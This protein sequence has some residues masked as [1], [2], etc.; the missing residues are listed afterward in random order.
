MEAR[1]LC[2]L[3]YAP[4]RKQQADSPTTK[5][6][7]LVRKSHTTHHAWLADS[8]EVWSRVIPSHSGS[9]D[10]HVTHM[11]GTAN[12]SP[13]EAFVSDSGKKWPA[14]HV[15]LLLPDKNSIFCARS[16]QHLMVMV[17]A[18]KKNRDFGFRPLV[19]FVNVAG[20]HVRLFLSDKHNIAS[21]RRLQ[22]LAVMVHTPHLCPTDSAIVDKAPYGTATPV[23][24]P[25]DCRLFGGN[26][27]LMYAH[28]WVAE[29]H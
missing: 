11:L 5:V 9:E 19:D 23:A 20:H 29:A 25:C 15:R 21:A 2:K 22:H 8:D 27:L 10:T 18:R 4:H 12:I 16:S 26:S 14:H 13:G 17:H 6:S 3:A 1:R 7:V 24:H 28:S